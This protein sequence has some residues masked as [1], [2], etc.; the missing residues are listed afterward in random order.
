MMLQLV[1]AYKKQLVSHYVISILINL[2][3]LAVQEVF[4]CLCGYVILFN[5]TK[6]NVMHDDILLQDEHNFSP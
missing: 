2:I 5:N 3:K 6:K 4:Y 1:P